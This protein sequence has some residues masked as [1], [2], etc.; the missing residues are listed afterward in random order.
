MV[1]DLLYNT[2]IWYIT[3]PSIEYQYI[4]I[5][6]EVSTLKYLVLV[7]SIFVLCEWQ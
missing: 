1:N 6:V 7:T 4:Y 3:F 5:S 2:Y